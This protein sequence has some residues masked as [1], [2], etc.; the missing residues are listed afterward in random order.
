[1]TEDEYHISRYPVSSIKTIAGL[2]DELYENTD[3]KEQL[4]SQLEQIV[5]ELK[6]KKQ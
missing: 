2:V 5:Q 1:M 6:E 3:E 4:I